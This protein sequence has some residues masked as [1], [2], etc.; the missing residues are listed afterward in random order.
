MRIGSLIGFSVP[1]FRPAAETANRLTSVN[2]VNGKLAVV[3]ALLLSLSLP[4][5]ATAEPPLF[6]QQEIDHLLRYVE[7]SGCEFQRNGSWYDSQRALSHLR[8]KYAFL[9]NS[10]RTSEDFIDIAASSSS[11][12]GQP[13]RVR[14]GS[15]SAVLSAQWLQDELLRFRSVLSQDLR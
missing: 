8:S 5:T 6:A 11:L 15:G 9:R 1:I 12:T 10:V 13:Y 4:N 3:L 2:T 14:C 7:N